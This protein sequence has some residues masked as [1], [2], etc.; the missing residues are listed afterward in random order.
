MTY[1]EDDKKVYQT[2]LIHKSD[3]IEAVKEKL[4]TY[5]HG[6][7]IRIINSVPI[8]KVKQKVIAKI[9]YDE[10]KLKDKVMASLKEEFGR[11]ELKHGYWVWDKNGMDWNIGAW[12]CSE[13]GARNSNIGSSGTPM[14]DNPMNW[15]GSKFCPNCGVKMGYKNEVH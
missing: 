7:V 9:H 15:S 10:D 11:N 4:P 8:A 5:M 13:C 2:D 1:N 14:L 3:I 12:R 6:D